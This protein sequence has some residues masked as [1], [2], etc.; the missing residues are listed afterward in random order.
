MWVGGRVHIERP[1]ALG[2]EATRT[3]DV[4]EAERKHGGRAG[5]FW[6]VTVQ[7]TIRQAGA[8]CIRE[9]QH[10][11][12][13]GPGELA[14]PGPDRDDPPPATWREART[15]DPVLLFRFSA[16]TNNAHRIHYDH[17]YAVAEEG[18]PDL[19]VHGPLTALL[20]AEFAH[21]STGRQASNVAF[22][23]HVPHFANRRFWLTAEEQPDST[24]RAVAMRG[25]HAPAM[26]VELR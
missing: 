18:Y 13:R 1:L 6:L 22:R 19:V 26:T 21:R 16:A 11:A 8:V 3:S 4:I 9:E 12:F 2:A 20:L 25:D 14:P 23:A 15:A 5:T 10:L 17:P 7:H 24:I